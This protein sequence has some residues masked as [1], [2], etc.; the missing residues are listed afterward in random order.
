M[1]K[2]RR[3]KAPEDSVGEMIASAVGHSIPVI[4]PVVGPLV[5]IGSDYAYR[6][7]YA[8]LDDPNATAEQKANARARIERSRDRRRGE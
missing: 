6:R 5:K 1:A 4:G 3:R 8:I 2:R 7:D